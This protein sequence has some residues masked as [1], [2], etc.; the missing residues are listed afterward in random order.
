MDTDVWSVLFARL[1]GK[2]DP[3]TESWRRLLVGRG[4]VI[5]T[6]TKAEVL[7]GLAIKD[8]GARRRESILSQLASTNQVPVTE[9]VVVAYADLTADC[10]RAGHALYAKQHT[11]D[12]WVAATAIAIGVPL[13]AGDGI[14]AGAPGLEI[15]ADSAR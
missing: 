12:R 6:Q 9:D 5:A 11:G 3:R 10:K 7:A 8:V 14:Y 4:V 15:L 2:P 1:R 13:L